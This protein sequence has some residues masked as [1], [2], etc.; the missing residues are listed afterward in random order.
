MSQS[1][2]V[3]K[4]SGDLASSLLQVN[5]LMYKM[6]PEIGITRHK[7]HQIDLPQQSTY[8]AGSQLIVEAQTGSAFVDCQKSYMTFKIVATGTST[9]SFGVGSALNVIQDSLVLSR[10]GVELSRLFNT[11]L[12]G[13]YKKD[14]QNTRD[15]KVC[16]APSQGGSTYDAPNGVWVP[17]D[18]TSQITVSIPMKDIS[19]FFNQKKLLPPQI[20]EG[21]RIRLDLASIYTASLSAATI[22]GYTISDPQFH[23][24]TV[25]L[26]DA[27]RRKVAEMSAS[28][29]LVLLHKEVYHQQTSVNGTALNFEIRKAASKALACHIVP[30]LIANVNTATKDSMSS[31]QFNF[32]SASSHIGAD[33]FPQQALANGVNQ[34]YTYCLQAHN[35][36]C[37][38]T[39]APSALYSPVAADDSYF[40][41][42]NS[43]KSQASLAFDLNKSGVSDLDGYVINNSRAL[44]VDLSMAS[45]NRRVDSFLE[46]LRACKIYPSNVEVRD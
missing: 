7:T 11:N 10:T 19:P 31:E 32:N 30:R 1:Q 35:K 44:V 40:G 46:H 25:H 37:D 3:S 12:Y 39:S 14:W 9:S 17:Q 21:L 4:P 29:G 34:F 18:I 15:W 33:F 36:L 42:A 45:A 26:A 28:R 16:V 13:K 27:F 43:L 38:G 8:S 6:A 2:S 24:S 20:M 23:W 41:D 22:T 5:R